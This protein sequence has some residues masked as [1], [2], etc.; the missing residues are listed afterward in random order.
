MKCARSLVLSDLSLWLY[1][2]GYL[3]AVQAGGARCEHPADP[4]ALHLPGPD[5][6]HGLVFWLS[7]Y[8]LCYVQE[9][10][11]TG[12]LW[13]VDSN[14]S[15]WLSMWCKCWWSVIYLIG[16]S[17]CYS[18]TLILLVLVRLMNCYFEWQKTFYVCL[19]FF[20]EFHYKWNTLT[21]GLTISNMRASL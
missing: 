3:C 11:G 12:R 18:A 4:A 9:R 21:T 16:C 15:M 13:E 20:I 19:T 6:P 14:V 2:S 7:L 8:P 1:S 5:I 10:T 17:Q